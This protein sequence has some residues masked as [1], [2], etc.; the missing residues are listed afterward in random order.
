MTALALP[1]RRRLR[2]VMPVYRMIYIAIGLATLYLIVTGLSW[3]WLPKYLPKLWT[4]FQISLAIWAA[5]VIFGFLIALPLGL[6]QVLSRGP[7]RW[8]SVA[9]CTTLRGTPLLMQL[10][11]FYYGLGAMMTQ[12]PGIRSTVLWPYLREAWPFAVLALSLNF[13][14]YA[15]EIMRGAFAGVGRGEIEAGKAFGMSST[16]VFF[17]IWLPLALRQALPTLAGETVMQLKAIPL[18]ATVTVPEMYAVIS[19]SRHD[20]LLTYEPLL[21]IAGIYLSL[22]FLLVQALAA[23]ERRFSLAKR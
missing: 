5:S 16:K 3:D 19:Q 18:V 14:A 13:A 23:V 10:W 6:A 21:L 4:G 11:L 15:G 17:R 7:L 8:L 12:I 1:T 20:T 2:K 9:Y 22:T